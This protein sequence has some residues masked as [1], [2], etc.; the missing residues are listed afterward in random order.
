M[1]RM[2]MGESYKLA[3]GLALKNAEHADNVKDATQYHVEALLLA[4]LSV[5]E[6]LADL[7]WHLN[8]VTQALDAIQREFRWASSAQA[9]GKDDGGPKETGPSNCQPSGRPGP[10]RPVAPDNAGPD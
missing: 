6:R 5:G 8:E 1:C 9:E 7:D 4:I 3:A 2:S 10:K